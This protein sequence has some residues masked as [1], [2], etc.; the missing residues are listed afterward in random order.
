MKTI[1]DV[2]GR[3]FIVRDGPRF[4]LMPCKFSIGFCIYIPPPWEFGGSPSSYGDVGACDNPSRPTKGWWIPVPMLR[5]LEVSQ[6]LLF[7][8]RRLYL[9]KLKFTLS[10]GYA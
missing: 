9:P 7:C 2:D 10:R 1:R 8:W 3:E 6:T 4:G 5:R